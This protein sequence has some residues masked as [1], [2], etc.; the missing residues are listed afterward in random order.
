MTAVP[1]VGENS[2]NKV[3]I[4]TVVALGKLNK[5]PGHEL[6]SAQRE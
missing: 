2:N 4:A 3:A 1:V 5:L 6:S